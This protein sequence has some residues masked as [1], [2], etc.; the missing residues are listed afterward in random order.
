MSYKGNDAV[1]SER[2]VTPCFSE[3]AVG[4]GCIV[5]GLSSS[6]CCVVVCVYRRNNQATVAACR[7]VYIIVSWCGPEMMITIEYI[8]E[9]TTRCPVLDW[10]WKETMI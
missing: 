1:G 10:M 4:L 7:L 3:L 9:R 8:D 6:V 5:I 2:A